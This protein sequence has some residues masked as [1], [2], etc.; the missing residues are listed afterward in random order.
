MGDAYMQEREPTPEEVESYRIEEQAR[1]HRELQRRRVIVT[2][3]EQELATLLGLPEGVYM[4]SVHF[5]WRCNQLEI[6]VYG[7]RFDI[8]PDM[9]EPP[10][11]QKEFE[12]VE[13]NKSAIHIVT[14]FPEA[15]NA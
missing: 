8:V 3:N 2:L 10:I 15:D 5:N 12:F 11:V 6:V 7:E 4:R 9:V 1:R 14:K 13:C